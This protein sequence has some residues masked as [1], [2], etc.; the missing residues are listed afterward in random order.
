MTPLD[1]AVIVGGLALVAFLLWFFFGPKTGKA[2]VFQ[3]GVQEATVRVEG[4]YEPN[5][6][7]VRAGAPVR[8][9]FDRREATDCSNRVVLP[10]FEVSRALPAF[11]TTT[12]EFTPETPGSYPFACAMNMYR[13]TIVVE[14][15]DGAPGDGASDGAPPVPVPDDGPAQVRPEVAPRPDADERPARVT[16]LVR[17]MRSITTVTAIEDLLEREKGVERVQVNA[18]T[19]RAT[20]D[21][22]PG[23]ATPEALADAIR[24]AGYQ[25][26]ALK[27]G[28]AITDRGA[29][30]RPSE[31]ADVTRRF[32]VA[33]VLTVP[34]VVGAMW[35]L[36]AEVPDGPLGAVVG[37]LADPFVQLALTVPVL[38]Y[39]G[40]GFFKG[41]WHTLRNRTADMNTL[42]GI[43]T[44]AAFLYS[45][46]ATFFADWL[47]AQGVEAGV[48]YETA[49]VIVALILLG[50]LLEVRA[51]AGTS[52]AI[53][54]LLS[55]QARTARVRRDGRDVDVPVEEVQTGDLVVVRPGEK[56]PVDGVVVE[57]ESTLDESMVT[58]ESVPVTKREGDPVIGATI[59]R[60]GGF[61][62]EATKVGKDTTLA[63]IVR[64]V[65]EAQGSKAP[66]QRL[67]DVVSGYFVPAVIVVAVVTFV[68]WF[69][70][71]PEPAFVLA[72]L[73]TVAV[74]LIACPCALGLATPTSIMVATGKGA[75]N[76][77]LVKDAEALEVTGKL[78]A[79]VLDKTGTLT[80]GRHAVQ[81]VV[82]GAGTTEAAL[83]RAA[84]ALERGSEH[85][86]A[87]AVV[88]EAQARGLDVPAATDFR[89]ETGKGTAGRVEGADV[90][91]GNRRLM[92]ERGVD[93]APMAAEAER[94][95]GEGKTLTYV[96]SDGRL[97]GLVTT[98]DVVRETS[99]AA[100]AE[101]QRLGVE[102]AMMTGDNWGVA[103]AVAAEM[104]IE[105]VLAE[106]LPEHKASEVAKLQRQGKIT[107]MVGDGINDAPALAQADVGIAIG[108]G[109]DVAI[110]AAD[111]ALLKNDVMDVARTVA[112]SR[113]TMRN[114][115]Q[116]LFFAF[117]YNGLGIPVAAGLLYPFFGLT[118]SP[119]IAA[120]AMAA[121]SVSVVLN[122]LRLK[123]FRMPAGPAS[124]E[125]ATVRRPRRT[126]GEP[127]RPAPPTP[128]EAA[129]LDDP[130]AEPSK[131]TDP[132]CGMD[133]DP[134]T[135]AAT[136][137]HR[138]ETVSFC[139]SSCKERFDQ[140]PE[141]Y[142]PSDAE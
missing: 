136:S 22:V 27:G 51:K 118:L 3:A 23:L 137:E 69:V 9:H 92:D 2:A 117:V 108:S 104:G 131:V 70:W 96:A 130:A 7:T 87:E 76:G 107:A 33:A 35:H 46:G 65:Q 83:L 99:K 52:A 119:M 80:E 44:G 10:D 88:A 93:L 1:L 57:G 123:S 43:G 86:L 95:V 94:L 56:V 60:A 16:F 128:T 112:L 125:P 82:P 110:E 30:S 18:D 31:L 40:W 54:A 13:G 72:L 67:A 26:E 122:A 129:V 97:V 102:V 62:F 25:P 38:F 61:V 8:L 91:A 140:D 5:V 20:V 142:A 126:E 113:A 19:E 66:I 105:T 124:G 133:V 11:Q 48:Y 101:L 49:A 15:G 28:E 29:A 127:A 89:Y 64:L 21:Y 17:G 71:G 85:P 36:V 59:N 106:V 14:P 53:E 120:G 98:A 77:I 73:N 100:V 74:L 138:G 42:I 6:I 68:G 114:V 141:R 24:R 12:V 39:S 81:D 47:A 115:R 121:S 63:Q 111:V 55:L 78:D 103:R 50:R 132:V 84:A 58:G 32:V 109:T 41:T 134:A 34:L 135:A 37:F 79:V 75:Q 45:L 4:A 90:L 116:N 139:S